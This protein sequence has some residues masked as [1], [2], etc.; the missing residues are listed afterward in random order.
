MSSQLG[1][2]CIGGA[3]PDNNHASWSDLGVDVSC[4]LLARLRGAS[5]A[6]AQAPRA[7]PHVCTVPIAEITYKEKFTAP[8]KRHA[9]RRPADSVAP[10]TAGILS[11][12]RC[13]GAFTSRTPTARAETGGGCK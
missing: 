3:T 7:L 1:N 6:F 4:G 11:E 5:A 2:E 12:I 10:R 9:G 13:R 8:A